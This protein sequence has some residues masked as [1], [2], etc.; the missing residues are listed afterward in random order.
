[1]VNGN[2]REDLRELEPA[3]AGQLQGFVDDIDGTI[4]NIRR[5]ISSL[6]ADVLEVISDATPSLAGRTMPFGVL[7]SRTGAEPVEASS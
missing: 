4:R 2:Q 6:R 5:S 1:M 3:R 7:D